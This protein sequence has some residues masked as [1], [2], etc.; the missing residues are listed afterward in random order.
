MKAIVAVWRTEL[1]I[2]LRNG[3]QLL[4]ALGIP[5]G[6]LVFFS[7]IDAFARSGHDVI[8]SLAP[9]VLALAVMSAAMVSLGISTGFERYYGV[10]RRLGA[11]PLG[12]GRWTAAKVLLVLTIEAAQWAVLAPVALVLGWQPTAAGWP[13]AITAA[14]LG[15]LAFAGIGLTLAGTLP[16]LSNLAACNGLYLTLL[17][18]SGMSVPLDRLPRPLATAARAFPAAALGDILQS[19]FS[20]LVSV[21]PS[22]WPVLAA[23]AVVAPLAA[24]RLFRWM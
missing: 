6:V 2:N 19:A 16:G 13:V 11:S 5:L 1:A 12:R 3:E 24:V 22:S 23:W 18:T 7:Q 21:H 8:D 4:V 9:G 17:L 15:T 10:L 20:P 14:G